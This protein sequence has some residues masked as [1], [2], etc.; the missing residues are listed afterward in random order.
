MADAAYA[1]RVDFGKRLQQIDGADVVVDRFHRAADVAVGGREVVLILAER[2]IIGG[3]CHVAAP[4]EMQ[5]V[6]QVLVLPQP[7]WFFLADGDRLVQAEDGGDFRRELV[8]KEE[9][10][11]DAAVERIGVVRDFLPM[12]RFEFDIFQ[13]FDIQ[14]HRLF[15]TGD[16]PHYCLHVR[17]DVRLADLP[18]VRG[19]DR[20]FCT[21][22]IQVIR[23]IQMLAV[24][25]C[26]DLI[27][28]EGRRNHQQCGHE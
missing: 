6:L 10:R 13:N 12:K 1:G 28:G 24:G 26:R 17:E 25:R 21:V 5:C 11:V 23:E 27:A 9:I 20:M 3:E 4:G 19:T 14:R 22:G 7:G 15:G 18:V 8:R 2:R 16:R